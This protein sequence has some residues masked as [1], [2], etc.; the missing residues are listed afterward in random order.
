VA[1]PPL[2]SP[3]VATDSIENKQFTNIVRRIFTQEH[4]PSAVE[5]VVSLSHLCASMTKA[6]WALVIDAE[7][8]DSRWKIQG[9]RG[10]LRVRAVLI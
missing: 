10:T 8:S 5:R 3:E 6:C 2:R 1:Q 7:D 4:M 9:G